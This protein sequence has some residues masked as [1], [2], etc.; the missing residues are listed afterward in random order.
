MILGPSIGEEL[1]TEMGI[2]DGDELSSELGLP[3]GTELGSALRRSEGE[4]F[5]AELGAPH[6]EAFGKPLGNSLGEVLEA[7]S[8]AKQMGRHLEQHGST[9]GRHTGGGAQEEVRSAG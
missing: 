8:S 2:P 1:G 6:V 9:A 4:P 5:G 7:Q 3:V